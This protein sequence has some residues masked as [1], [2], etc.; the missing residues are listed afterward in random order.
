MTIPPLKI[1]RYF[2]SLEFPVTILR[3]AGDKPVRK[4]GFNRAELARLIDMGSVI[5]I[6][7]YDKIRKIRMYVPLIPPSKLPKD[8]KKRFQ[9]PITS[10]AGRTVVRQFLPEAAAHVWR[11][12]DGRCGAWPHTGGPQ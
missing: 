10:D 6:G 4:E 9:S 7:S 11:H 1:L 8:K 5:A 2:H 3:E 12:H